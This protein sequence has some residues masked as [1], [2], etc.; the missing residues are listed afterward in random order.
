[1]NF[2]YLNE[3][4][5]QEQGARP[6][7][8]ALRTDSVVEWLWQEQGAKPVRPVRPARVA[9]N[10]D[11]VVEIRAFR[12]REPDSAAVIE[13]TEILFVTGKRT[14]YDT[15]FDQVCAMLAQKEEKG[16]PVS[17]TSQTIWGL[18]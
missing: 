4:Q 14:V 5:E 15:S 8:P 11:N 6:V 13:A 16:L 17:L 2:I 3:Y 12:Y 18:K 1:M 10:L 7:R 9:V